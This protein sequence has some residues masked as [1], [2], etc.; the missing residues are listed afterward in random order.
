MSQK[1]HMLLSSEEVISRNLVLEQPAKPASP[2][3]ETILDNI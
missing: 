3:K 2:S 1:Q